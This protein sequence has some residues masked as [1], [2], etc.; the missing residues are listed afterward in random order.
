M[1]IWFRLNNDEAPQIAHLM[2]NEAQEL[3]SC[4]RSSRDGTPS[5]ASP[6]VDTITSSHVA[7]AVGAL[8]P[9]PAASAKRRGI[10]Q[11][12]SQPADARLTA[13]STSAPA[14][15]ASTAS[16]PN[17][18]APSA[19][20]QQAWDLPED[21]DAFKPGN[22][23]QLCTVDTLRPAVQPAT[24]LLH[25]IP[26]HLLFKWSQTVKDKDTALRNAT[27]NDVV[28][29]DGEM[30]VHSN[31]IAHT[32]MHIHKNAGKTWAQSAEKYIKVLGFARQTKQDKI[33]LLRMMAAGETH[34]GVRATV[35][36]AVAVDVP[37]LQELGRLLAVME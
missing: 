9:V 33:D 2:T 12:P 18:P 15:A 25:G 14:A 10:T 8:L 7:P 36:E 26:R 3:A 16:R 19:A 5:I 27:S 24:G 31:C 13:A 17:I 6:A 37:D 21:F 11:L 22:L 1:T 23:F 20:E 29:P 34:T 28:V 30:A 35:S 4:A 32:H